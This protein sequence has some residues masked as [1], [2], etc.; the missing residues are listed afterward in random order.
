[1]SICKD[2]NVVGLSGMIT[3]GIAEFTDLRTARNFIAKAAPLYRFQ[4]FPKGPW[5]F[6]RPA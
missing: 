4:L 2:L 5:A 6:G 3:G 1:M